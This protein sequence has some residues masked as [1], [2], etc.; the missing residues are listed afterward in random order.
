MKPDHH[1]G[2]LA[3]LV[4]FFLCVCFPL[5]CV[6]RATTCSA[7]D[8]SIHPSPSCPAHTHTDSLMV[9]GR[10]YRSDGRFSS[11]HLNHHQHHRLPNSASMTDDD[12]L[13]LDY[14]P[15]AAAGSSGQPGSAAS[16]APLA[17]GDEEDPHRT[18]FVKFAGAGDSDG[19]EEG[20]DT[21]FVRHNTPHP[22][23]LKAKAQKHFKSKNI[24]GKVVHHDEKVRSPSIQL[25]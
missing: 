18:S 2:R 14:D 20:R 11:E 16:P 6:G 24:D 23:D 1:L 7:L 13:S 25:F 9:E 12:A 10:L 21:P 19:D 3:F 15:F 22:K 8:P 5:G 17:G 4:F